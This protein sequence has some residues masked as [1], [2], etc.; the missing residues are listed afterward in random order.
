[1]TAAHRE[2]V[3]AGPP[4]PLAAPG[5]AERDW[6]AWAALRRLPRLPVTDWRSAVILAAHPDGEVLVR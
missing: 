6:Q 4:V 1:V 2:D 5:T 3:T